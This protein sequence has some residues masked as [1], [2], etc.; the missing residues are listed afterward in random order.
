MRLSTVVNSGFDLDLRHSS[1]IVCGLQDVWLPCSEPL[2]LSREE[3]ICFDWVQMFSPE[4]L[5]TCL[6]ILHSEGQ[7]PA[8]NF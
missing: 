7:I 1:R 8:L 5:K 6:V 4:T 3:R 2:L